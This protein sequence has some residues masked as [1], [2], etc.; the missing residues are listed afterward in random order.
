MD[1]P[2]EH[3]K[4]PMKPFFVILIIFEVLFL[5]ALAVGFYFFAVPNNPLKAWLKKV[6]APPPEVK[7]LT[8]KVGRLVLLP[9]NEEPTIATVSDKTKLQDQPF[10][11]RAENG[12]KVLIFTKAKKAILYRP[13]TDKIIE[14][15]PINIAPELEEKT[16]ALEKNP[17]TPA[18]TPS[19]VKKP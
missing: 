11:S 9:K 15:A 19:G 10:F 13:K 16:P 7:V 17:I 3:K 8:Q 6:T 5:I 12:D 1:T 18:A 4:P 2:A 14:I